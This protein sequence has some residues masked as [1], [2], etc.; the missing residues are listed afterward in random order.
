MKGKQELYDSDG[1]KLKLAE[2]EELRLED[3][4]ERRLS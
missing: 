2:V 1:Y 3:A 4:E